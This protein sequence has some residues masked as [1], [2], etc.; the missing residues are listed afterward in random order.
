M[1]GSYQN[2]VESSA[3][4]RATNTRAGSIDDGQNRAWTKSDRQEGMGFQR[5]VVN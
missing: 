4:L 2:V 5:F 3:I 1:K